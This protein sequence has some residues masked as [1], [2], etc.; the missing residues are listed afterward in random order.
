MQRGFAF[1]WGRCFSELFG[2]PQM[3]ALTS[4]LVS[5]WE[6]L[7][8]VLVRAQCESV[9]TGSERVSCCSPVVSSWLFGAGS[10]QPEEAVWV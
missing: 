4:V 3:L 9:G 5:S 2:W 10:M 7:K 6:Y 8:G 1:L